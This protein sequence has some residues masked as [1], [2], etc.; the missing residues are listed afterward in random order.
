VAIA[1]FQA[2]LLPKHTMYFPI[3]GAH[4]W[5]NYHPSRSI[6]HSALVESKG[7]IES[8]T[9]SMFSASGSRQNLFGF[10][11]IDFRVRGNS[12]EVHGDF[13]PTGCRSGRLSVEDVVDHLCDQ[14]GC[15]A[16]QDKFGADPDPVVT[17]DHREPCVKCLRES[18]L[19]DT[20][21]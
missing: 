19:G 17:I 8:H 21:R 3:P 18:L 14:I 2:Y 15:N 5:F 4:A 1:G 16:N 7:R 10:L 12:P 11:M 9:T 6:S 13:R 20:R